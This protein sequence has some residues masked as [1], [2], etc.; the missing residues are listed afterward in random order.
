MVHYMFQIFPI[1]YVLMSRKTAECY[2][3]VFKYVEEHVL[4]LEAKEFIT[5]F[6]GGL[7]KAVEICYPNSVLRGC[8]FHFCAALRKKA[9]DLDLRTVL[10][11]NAE[12]RTVLS[13][14]MSIPLLPANFIIAGFNHIMQRAKNVGMHSEFSKLFT[15]FRSYWLDQQVMII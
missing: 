13:M 6:E 8:W 10:K 5:D 15:Y 1:C 4:K 2:V 11:T 3:D 14:L 12:A 7:R 9:M